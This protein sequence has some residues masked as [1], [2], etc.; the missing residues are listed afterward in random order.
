[1]RVKISRANSVLLSGGGPPIRGWC[2]GGGDTRDVGD[3][4]D[5][6]F[7]LS[8]VVERERASSS[9]PIARSYDSPD[10]GLSVL[11]AAGFG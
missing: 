4:T 9:N 2:C 6:A 7:E 1:M 8:A 11:R 5:A 3:A 10:E